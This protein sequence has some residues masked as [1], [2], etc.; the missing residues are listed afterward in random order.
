MKEITGGGAQTVFHAT[1]TAQV[2][3]DCIDAAR[4]AGKVI[5]VGATKD[6][7]EMRLRNLLVR[8]LDIRASHWQEDRPHKYYP[9]T[10]L[11][12]R[13]AVMRMIACGDLKVDHLISHVV[14]P[15]EADRLYRQMIDGPKGWMGIFFDWT[16]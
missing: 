1:T 14:K 13:F 15:E 7:L 3:S 2:L 11:R 12:D 10:T 16:E 4:Y 6:I 5:L 8:E 9:W